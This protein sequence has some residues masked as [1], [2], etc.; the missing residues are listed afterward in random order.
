[1]KN[2]VTGT[3]II[4]AK[5]NELYRKYFSKFLES[6]GFEIIALAGSDEEVFELLK[7]NTPD[8][9]I[10]DLCLTSGGFEKTIRKILATS[11]S[12]KLILTGEFYSVLIENAMILGA[13]GFF[14]EDVTDLDLIIDSIKRISLGEVVVLTREKVA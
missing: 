12:T 11:P 14:D 8:I 1:M 2:L 9:L 13:N 3:K 4:L 5:E 7:T 6:N 10:Y